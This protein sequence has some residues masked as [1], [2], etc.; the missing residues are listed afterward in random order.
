METNEL[1]LSTPDGAMRAYEAAPPDPRGAVIVVPEAYGLNEHIEAVANRYAD[2][3]FHALGIDVFH[4][5]GGGT[6]AYDDDFKAVMALSV[7]LDDEGFLAD[8]DAAIAHLTSR[9]IDVSRQGVVGY[10][11]G[12]RFSFLAALRRPL[13]AAISYY[14]GGI[15]Q[16]GAFRALPAI[17]DEV[18]SL[19]VAWLGFFGDLDPS[20]PSD[21]VATLR[22]A[23]A[24]IDVD[25][26]IVQYP[27]ATHG[28][29]CEAR[30]AYHA[31]ASADAFD[32]AVAWLTLHLG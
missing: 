10:C 16:Q 5:S 9:G 15:V 8:L 12:G 29:N 4:R 26:E 3:G 18:P 14:G 19:R 7:G 6:A 28:F 32:R 23:L 11:I 22:K 21:D 30:S 2:A 1:Q 24:D 25:V 27:D 20:I 13:G 31:E 17:L